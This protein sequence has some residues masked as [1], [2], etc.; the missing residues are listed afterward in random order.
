M[1]PRIKE[2]LNEDMADEPGSHATFTVEY[3]TKLNC[4]LDVHLLKRRVGVKPVIVSMVIDDSLRDCG[5]DGIFV[6][7]KWRR[8]FFPGSAFPVC[9]AEPIWNA[10]ASRRPG[11]V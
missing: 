8:L 1:Q 3:L 4:E 6:V 5:H 9:R 2:Q 10:A 7:D 11:I